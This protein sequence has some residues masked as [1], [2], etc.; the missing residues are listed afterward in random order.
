MVSVPIPMISSWANPKVS[1]TLI[2]VVTPVVLTFAR[3]VANP[4][5]LVRTSTFWS[6]LNGVNCDVEIPERY[7]VSPLAI[8]CGI[9]VIPTILLSSN[10]K[11]VSGKVD[12]PIC[13]VSTSEPNTSET[14]IFVP[15]PSVPA[16]SNSRL[17]L[18][19]Y[20]VPLAKIVTDD[21]PEVLVF[22]TLNLCL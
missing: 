6:P 13:T 12:T 10:N 18:T 19:L 14:T 17:S 4:T 11:V 16:L 21:I 8:S 5:D 7:I 2:Y 9:V 15:V 22:V 3:S 1:V 20:S